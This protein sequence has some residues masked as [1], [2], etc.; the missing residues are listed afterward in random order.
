MLFF[1]VLCCDWNPE[2]SDEQLFKRYGWPSAIKAVSMHS[3]AWIQAC[4]CLAFL[5]IQT[6]LDLHTSVELQEETAR[7]R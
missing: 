4:Y 6:G 5:S 3:V 2:V 1:A 7:R